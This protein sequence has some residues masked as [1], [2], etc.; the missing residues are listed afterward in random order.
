[1]T[2]EFRSR[3]KKH[4]V[5]FLQQ[6]RAT[7]R[8][9]PTGEECLGK[10]DEFC[11]EYYPSESKLTKGIALKWAESRENEGPKTRQNRISLVRQLRYT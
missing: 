3:F 8:T 2:K 6:K 11:A 1:M 9:Y 7:G 5:G 4:L 10:F